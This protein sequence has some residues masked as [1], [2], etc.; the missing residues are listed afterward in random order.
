[1][2]ARSPLLQPI[3]PFS[4]WSGGRTSDLSTFKVERRRES[5]LS[6]NSSSSN[7]SFV[8]PAVPRS[9]PTF[10][11]LTPSPYTRSSSSWDREEGEQVQS[12]VVEEEAAMESSDTSGDPEACDWDAPASIDWRQFHVHL[13]QIANDSTKL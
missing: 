8:F 9:Q 3:D 6:L 10:A 7:V 11:T 4:S 5:F 12:R 13:L 2:N 1:M